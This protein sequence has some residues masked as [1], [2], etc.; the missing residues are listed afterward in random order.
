M[1]HVGQHVY[2]IGSGGQP[3]TDFDRAAWAKAAPGGPR[4]GLIYTVRGLRQGRSASGLLLDEIIAPTGGGGYDEIAWNTRCFR[5]VD[6]TKLSIFREMLVTPP[7]EP[8][9]A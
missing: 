8:V 6:E 5:P 9:S 4:K 7:K 2:C 1:F 3:P